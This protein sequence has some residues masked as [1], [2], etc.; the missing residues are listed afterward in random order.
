MVCF[1]VHFRR[2]IGKT[3]LQDEKAMSSGLKANEAK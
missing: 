1:A 2:S 3:F